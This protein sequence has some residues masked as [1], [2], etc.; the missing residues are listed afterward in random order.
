M[1][2]EEL[3]NSTLDIH[4]FATLLADERFDDAKARE[5]IQRATMRTFG[6]TGFG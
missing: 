6:A 2:E 3:L 1:V 5:S 4:P